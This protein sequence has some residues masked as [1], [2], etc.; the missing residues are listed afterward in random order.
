LDDDGQQHHQQFPLGG[1]LARQVTP[2]RDRLADARQAM[3]VAVDGGKAVISSNVK[4]AAAG[5]S[6]DVPLG[7]K[8]D[9]WSFPHLD[10]IAV[11]VADVSTACLITRS[12]D[13][14]H[15]GGRGLLLSRISEFAPQRIALGRALVE[16]L[17]EIG[18]DLLGIG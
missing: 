17:L 6:L 13:L 11:S 9:S 2:G 7:H 16:L 15:L 5:A 3:R 8:D 14:Q 18:G 10:T 4:V 12:C 1:R